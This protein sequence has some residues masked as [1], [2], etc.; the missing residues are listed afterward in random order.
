MSN[1]S[2]NTPAGRRIDALLDP[3]SFVELAGGVTSRST[4]FNEGAAKEPSDGVITGYGLMDGRLVYIYSQNAAVLNGTV[5]E[6]HAKKII[7]LYNMAMKMG[8]PV[9]GLLDSAGFRLNEATDVLEAL[10][11]L[12]YKE[13]M[14]SGVIPQISAIFGTC[15]GGMAVAAS[16]TDF[17][18]MEKENGR[19]FLNAP[20]AIPGK[21]EESCDLS[22]ADFQSAKSG[23]VDFVGDE[24]EV[25]GAIKTL[26]GMLP[27]NNEEN[28]AYEECTDD[29]NR[30]VDV[31]NAA[32]DPAIIAY[33][34]ADNNLFF[35]TKKDYAKDM[36]TGF[37]RLGGS[38]VGVIANRKKVYGAD[39]EVTECLDG[40]TPFGCYKAATFVSFCDA[41]EIP[42]LTLSNVSGF[43]ACDW[44][45]QGLGR[46][47]ARLV[48]ALAAASV[49]KI[50]VITGELM[51]SAYSI[52][53]SKALGADL[54]Y[55]WEGAKVGMMEADMAAKILNPDASADELKEKSAEYAEKLS[56]ADAA[57]AR[58]YVDA[59][60]D[61]AQTRKYLIGAFDMLM[62]KQEERPFKKHGTK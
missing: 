30:L 52:M 62:T 11:R 47:S 14:A 27:G 59:L 38:T 46:T 42:V 31:A 51:G 13:T 43:Y 18:L 55:A 21:N 35:E 28:D 26:V 41:F 10:S 45:E 54:V 60:I 12:Y 33:H 2:A 44:A 25:L 49:P 29:L 23:N 3:G 34:L 39:G 61:P 57:Y 17:V 36:M 24:G 32:D 58:G 16:L 8:A 1:T 19:Y 22:K 5:G 15:G 4:D 40:L 7:H 50:N 53:N 20:N 48:S 56:S 6:M 9:I 37:L